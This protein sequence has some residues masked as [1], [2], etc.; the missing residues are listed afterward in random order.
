MDQDNTL[1]TNPPSS[2]HNLVSCSLDGM[3][4]ATG[5]VERVK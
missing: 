5:K 4:H 3:K 1:G 2:S